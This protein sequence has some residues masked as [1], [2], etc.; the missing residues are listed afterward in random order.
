MHKIGSSYDTASNGLIAVE[1]YQQSTRRFDYILMGMISPSREQSI[2]FHTDRS[3]PD[4][5]MPIMDGITASSEIRDYEQ[6]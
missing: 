4:I 5:S 2:A 1:K 3:T 6:Q